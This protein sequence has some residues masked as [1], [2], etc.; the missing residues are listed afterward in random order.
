MTVSDLNLLNNPLTDPR[1]S[2]IID[3]P[4]GVGANY[5]WGVDGYAYDN[6]I[7]TVAVDSQQVLDNCGEGFIYRE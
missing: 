5:F 1:D 6:C 3:D 7:V 2:I 4:D